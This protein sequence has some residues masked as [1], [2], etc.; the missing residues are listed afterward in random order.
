MSIFGT[1]LLM[2]SHHPSFDT[3]P[4]ATIVVDAGHLIWAA[5]DLMKPLFGYAPEEL[6]GQPVDILV[7]PDSRSAFSDIW[8]ALDHA[9]PTDSGL[10]GLRKDGSQFPIDVSLRKLVN[11]SGMMIV[12]L[13][14]VEARRDIDEQARQVQKMA[15]I[16]RLA[17]G[18][19]HDF[20]NILAIILGQAQLLLRH[21]PEEARDRARVQRII[22]A[23]DRAAAL[24]HQ[25]LALSRKPLFDTRVLDLNETVE[26]QLEPLRSLVGETVEVVLRRG[27]AIGG[28]L[29]DAFQIEQILLNLAAN[30]RD[31]MAGGGRL[32]LETSNAEM[33]NDYIRIHPGA[34]AGRYVCL[35]VSDTG[36]GMTR[37]V[38]ARAFEPFFTTRETG[39]GGPGL[40]LTTVFGIV[41]QSN[42]FIYLYSEPGRGTTVKIYLPRADGENAIRPTVAVPRASETVLLVDDEET[43][44]EMIQ[45]VLEDNG[46]RV[47]AAADPQTALAIAARDDSEI[48]LLLTD[49]IMPGIGGPELARQLRSL[50]PRV[51]VLYM[52]GYTEEAMADRGEL[53]AG[54]LLISKPFTQESLTRKLRE[55]LAAAESED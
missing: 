15:A 4:E 1:K 16:D 5:T 46:Y 29:G 3:V 47:L 36:H 27:Q 18:V 7:A 23:G 24:T 13:R 33:D 48:H 43:L 10:F 28:T 45:E 35:A 51:G 31:A 49:V 34:I 42:G 9:A 30:A 25:L 26:A 53:E 22:A 40:G 12:T 2:R 19:A 41:Q 11:A 6:A 21:M 32:T 50:R 37:E 52:S 20:N 39:S 44:R 55:A 8:I 38:R 14:D 17:G 54:A